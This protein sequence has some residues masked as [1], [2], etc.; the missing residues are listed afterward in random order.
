MYPFFCSTNNCTNISPQS[1]AHVSCFQAFRRSAS[2][3]TT[4]GP[5]GGRDD[6]GL[7]LGLARCRAAAANVRATKMRP[8]TVKFQGATWKT[9]MT[10][11]AN[12]KVIQQGWDHIQGDHIQH[13]TYP[14]WNHWNLQG[15]KG[16]F[17]RLTLPPIGL[18]VWKWKMGCI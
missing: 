6:V 3:S 2:N 18:H 7:G 10:R 5:S 1:L 9:E 8:K 11:K 16:M 17:D 12:L 13:I 15:G 14:R 4:P